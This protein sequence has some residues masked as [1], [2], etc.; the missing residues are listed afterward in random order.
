MSTVLRSNLL[1]DAHSASDQE[2]SSTGRSPAA[3]ALPNWRQS[4]PRIVL[5]CVATLNLV[6]LLLVVRRF[7]GALQEPFP[8]GHMLFT[9]LITTALAAYSRTIWR[10]AKRP[11]RLP[12]NKEGG[13]NKNGRRDHPPGSRLDRWVVDRWVVDRWVG[14]GSSLGLALLAVGCTYPAERLV[15]WLVWFPLLVADQF[16]RQ[17]FFDGRQPAAPLFSRIYGMRNA[18][19]GMRNAGKQQGKGQRRLAENSAALPDNDANSPATVSQLPGQDLSADNLAAADGLSDSLALERGEQLLQQLFRIRNAAGE[20]TIYGTLRADFEGGQRNASLYVGFCP[21]LTHPPRV[22]AE[23]VDGPAATL[24][25]VQALAHGARVDL[26][27]D[28]PANQDCHVMVDLA[29][30][31][32]G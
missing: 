8:T 30:L 14:W 3:H 18:E 23:P 1:T 26:R 5:A 19:C 7:G 13:Q 25:V 21:P 17:S 24:K 2:T 32:S 16:W 9:A 12:P 10:R 29:A 28:R 27:L 4:L 6:G 15:D 11:P 22:E 31:G 20:E